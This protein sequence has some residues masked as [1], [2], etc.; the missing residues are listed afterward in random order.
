M[1]VVVGSDH[2]GYELKEALKAHIAELGH[3]VVDVGAHSVERSD[4]PDF[5]CAVAEAIKTGE[6]TRGVLMCGSGVGASIAA[7]KVPGVRAGVCHDTYSA[8]VIGI[9]LAKELV[10]AFLVA[11]FQQEERFVRRL[12]KVLAIE[13]EYSRE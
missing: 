12:N 10:W 4:Y 13:A 7:N 1:R 11:E 3:D 9:E 5:A 8:R 2:A 6:A